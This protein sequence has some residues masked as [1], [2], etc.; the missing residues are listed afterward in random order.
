MIEWP[1]NL[2]TDA[3]YYADVQEATNSHSFD[4]LR[5]EEDEPYEVWNELLPVRDWTALEREWSEY[6]SSRSP[7]EVVSSKDAALFKD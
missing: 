4:M 5:D 1:D 7:G 2:D 3:W 6:D